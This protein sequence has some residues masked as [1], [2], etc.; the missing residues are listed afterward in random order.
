MTWKISDSCPIT[1]REDM[2]CIRNE[3]PGVQGM[4]KPKLSSTKEAINGVLVAQITNHSTD[5]AIRQALTAPICFLS[6]VTSAVN[7]S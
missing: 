2:C 7:H 4:R 3:K 5:R 1:H 6:I